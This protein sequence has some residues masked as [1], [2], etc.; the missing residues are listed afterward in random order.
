[1]GTLPV[2]IPKL[3]DGGKYTDE[4]LYPRGFGLRYALFRTFSDL[5]SGAWYVGSVGYALGQG[6]MAGYGNGTFGTQ[7]TLS[8]AEM[9]TMLWRMAGKPTA[10]NDMPFEDR[11]SLLVDREW[12]AR[13]NNQLARLKKAA[14]FADPSA[15]VENIEYHADRCLDKTMIARLATCAYI[16]EAHN[17]ILMGATGTGKTYL[18]CALGMAAV[19]NFMKVRYVRLPE[20]FTELAIAP[21]V[22]QQYKRPDLLILD[23][24]LLYG[25]KETEARD[26]LEIIEARHKVAST[27]FCSQFSVRGWQDKIGD[28]I[29]ADAICDRIVHDSYTL[30]V[31]GKES[32]RKRKGIPE[33]I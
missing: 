20:L 33:D 24:W 6:I 2:N 11:V 15:C 4:I 28:P 26:L 21:K 13:K 9:V 30:L 16:T 12:C 17:V 14:H 27:I 1:M 31:E 25:L 8:R 7:D 23:E 19:R 32:M 22:I 29:L 5:E 18:A 3:D 10:G